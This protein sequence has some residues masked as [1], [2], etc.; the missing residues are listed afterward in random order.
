MKEIFKASSTLGLAC[1][2]IY[3]KCLPIAYSQINE[4]I[5]ELIFEKLD[6]LRNYKKS[7]RKS[8]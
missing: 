8:N 6:L 1:L 5:Y 3:T 4:I 7:K 2:L